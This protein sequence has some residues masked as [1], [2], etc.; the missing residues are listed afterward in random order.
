MRIKPTS[1]LLH[2]EK[3]Y[4]HLRERKEKRVGV[5]LIKCIYYKQRQSAQT[6]GAFI[7]L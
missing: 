5:I 6:L 4:A 2:A 7:V 3:Y 1:A